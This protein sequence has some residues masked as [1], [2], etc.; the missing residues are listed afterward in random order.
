MAEGLSSWAAM[1]H[2]S[3]FSSSR[4]LSHSTIAE[5]QSNSKYSLVLA[6]LGVAFPLYLSAS[7]RLPFPSPESYSALSTN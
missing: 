3:K 1:G 7:V 4:I 5:L 2:P 6:Y